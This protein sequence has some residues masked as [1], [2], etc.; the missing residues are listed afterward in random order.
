MQGAVCLRASGPAPDAQAGLN[1]LHLLPTY[2]F[3]SVP[4]RREDQV[5]VLTPTSTSVHSACLPYERMCLGLLCYVLHVVP[6]L[7]CH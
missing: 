3:G 1:H 6:Y 2:D 4:E 5:G 7:Q